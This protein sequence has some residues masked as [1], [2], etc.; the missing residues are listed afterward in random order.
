MDIVQQL[1]PWVE[2]WAPH[3]L[4]GGLAGRMAQEVHYFVRGDIVRAVDNNA[5]FCGQAGS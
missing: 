1:S 2:E 3:E 5:P 4:C